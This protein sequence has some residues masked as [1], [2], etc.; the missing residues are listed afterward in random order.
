[1]MAVP[2]SGPVN[3]SV[4]PMR[5]GAPL[6]AACAPPA[7]ASASSAAAVH[8]PAIRVI[9]FMFCL[10]CWLFVVD[11]VA[12]RKSE[13]GELVSGQQPAAVH[14]EVDAVDSLVVQQEQHR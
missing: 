11:R 4:L 9:V 10:Q 7:A 3:D 6:G 12:A 5:I 2:D 8:A 14:V 13:Q 1:M